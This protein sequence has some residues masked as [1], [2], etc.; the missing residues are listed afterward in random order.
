MAADIFK[1]KPVGRL[2]DGGTLGQH[3]AGIGGKRNLAT[4]GK[5]LSN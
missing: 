5:S 1:I 2:S 4:A 3:A